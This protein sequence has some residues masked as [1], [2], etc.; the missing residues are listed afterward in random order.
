MYFAASAI[1]TTVTTT[2]A[3]ICT[4]KLL[5]NL[6]MLLICVFIY[7]HL[8]Y[9]VSPIPEPCGVRAFSTKHNSVERPSLGCSELK[10]SLWSGSIDIV[11][12]T[13]ARVYYRL[14]MKNNTR[15]KFH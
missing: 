2:N 13:R 11:A 10:A 4:Q 12:L 9:L 5:A 1:M 3:A 7:G 6:P 14:A 15:N 8:P